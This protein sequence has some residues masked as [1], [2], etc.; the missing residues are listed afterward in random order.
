MTMAM[1]MANDPRMQ[2][3]MGGMMANNPMAQQMMAGQGA[4]VVQATA[5]A[6][7]VEDAADK[8]AKLKGLLDSGA[9]TEEEVCMLLC[10]R[11]RVCVCAPCGPSSATVAHA[12]L[13]CTRSPTL[14][15]RLP[16]ALRTRPHVSVG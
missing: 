16:C 14:H 1:G 4:P 12:L 9:I 13:F 7:P 6:V 15:I 11:A 10:A 8:I 3:L 2:N 5:T